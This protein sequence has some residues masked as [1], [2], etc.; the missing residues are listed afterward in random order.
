M[1]ATYVIQRAVAAQFATRPTVRTVVTHLLTEQLKQSFRQHAFDLSKTY[2]VLTVDAEGKA[3]STQRYRLLIEVLLEHIARREPLN[4]RYYTAQDCFVAMSDTAPPAG[5]F[6][7]IEPMRQ[8]EPVLLDVMRLWQDSSA[9]G[10]R[11]VLEST[12]RHRHQPH[13]LAGADDSGSTAGGH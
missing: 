5:G 11:C 1:Y 10:A 13:A 9:R 6:T 3:L 7:S 12:C 8:I 4:Y 2:L